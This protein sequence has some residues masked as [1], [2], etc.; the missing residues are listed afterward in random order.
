M[1]TLIFDKEVEN[2]QW[3]KKASSV[4]GAGLI[5]GRM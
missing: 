4:N 1:N 5:G 3:E 2:I